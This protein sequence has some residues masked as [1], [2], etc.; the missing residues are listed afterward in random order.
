MYKSTLNY[1]GAE[2]QQTN[3]PFKMDGA[4]PGVVNIQV[5]DQIDGNYKLLGMYKKKIR[6]IPEVY[7][8]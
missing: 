2:P 3:I 6:G 4:A 7:F 1:N 5:E 8:G